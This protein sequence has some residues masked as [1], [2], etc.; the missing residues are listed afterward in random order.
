[1]KFTAVTIV[2]F[3]AITSAGA[4]VALSNI[5]PAFSAPPKA[6][7]T[8]VAPTKTALNGLLSTCKND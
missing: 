3:N 6:P 1:M 8:T 5:A 7:S 4:F 2:A